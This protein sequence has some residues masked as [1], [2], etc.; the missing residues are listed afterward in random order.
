MELV[1]VKIS[2]LK[3][4][5]GNPRKMDDD[6]FRNLV[7]SLKEYGYVEPIIINKDKQV[8]GGNYRLKALRE[9]FE[10][11]AEVEA[12]TID[13][14]KNKEI[15]LNIILNKITG[16]FDLDKL[17]EVLISLDNAGESIND[18][19]FNEQELNII[20]EGLTELKSEYSQDGID[21]LDKSKERLMLIYTLQPLLL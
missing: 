12:V 1:K 7:N 16:E 20:T 14:P 5:E 13:L 17:R 8:I 4:Y 9:I 18:L 21:E 3:E 11:N 10:E 6:M 15:K 2:D 19:G